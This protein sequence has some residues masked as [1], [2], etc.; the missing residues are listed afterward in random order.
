MNK[1]EAQERLYAVLKRLADNST[2]NHRCY[3]DGEISRAIEAGKKSI[4]YS[5]PVYYTT[6]DE[7][8]SYYQKEKFSLNLSSILLENYVGIPLYS[9][10]IIWEPY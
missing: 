5:K 6:G 9:L 3:I 7:L 1:K 8:I 10:E 4:I 2:H